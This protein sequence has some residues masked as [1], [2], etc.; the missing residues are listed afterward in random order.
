MRRSVPDS[1]NPAGQPAAPVLTVTPFYEFRIRT[2]RDQSAFRMF[3]SGELD[4]A[5]ADQLEQTLAAALVDRGAV[6]LDL[7][8][9]TFLDSS[10]IEVFMGAAQRAQ[11]GGGRFHIVNSQ[12]V[13]RVFEMTGTSSLLSPQGIG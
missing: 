11:A 3:L 8:G 12:K 5:S 7:E 2:E 10:G 9:L 4:L 1:G 13:Q 6:V